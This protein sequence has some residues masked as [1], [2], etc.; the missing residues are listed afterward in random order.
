MNFSIHNGLKYGHASSALLLNFSIKFAV[1]GVR[2]NLKGLQLNGLNQ[3]F[4]C[5]NDV[6]LVCYITIP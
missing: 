4:V 2:E 1:S 5:V 6:S 3:I